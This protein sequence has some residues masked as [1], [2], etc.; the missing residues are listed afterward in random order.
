MQMTP[1]ARAWLDATVSRILAR[2]TIPAA[3][4]AGITYELMS[5]LHAAGEARATAAGRSDVSREDL[6]LAFLEADGDQGLAAAFVQPSASPVVRVLFGRRLGAF[7]IDAVLLAIILT[8]V[9]SAIEAALG[10]FM[11]EPGASA[12]HLDRWWQFMPWGFHSS[13]LALTLQ[14]VIALASAITV[15][16]YFT[17]FEANQGT[18]P[19]KRVLDLR[20]VRVDGRPMT[21]Q[22]SFIRN[23]VKVMPPLLIIDTAIMLLAFVDDKQRVSDKIAETIVVKASPA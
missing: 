1:D 10:P 18:S 12:M 4:R 21:Y 2:Y 13:A 5:H 8:V 7:A 19:G 6:E 20:V 3:D 16:G 11:S 22:E 17:W 9:H 23:V 14:A 15:I